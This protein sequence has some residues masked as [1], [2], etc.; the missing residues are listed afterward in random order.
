M[1]NRCV[2]IVSAKEPFVRWL[3]SLPEPDDSTVDQV[4]EET[5]A[6]LL[7]DDWDDR[8]EQELLA[9]FYDLIFEDQLAGWWTE[10]GDW[11]KRRDFTMFTRWFDVEFHS[12]VLDLV[13]A[14]L[15][16]GD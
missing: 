12:V 11:P 14:P 4:N 13:D 16:D 7:P 9:N 2:A 1:L 3:R 6:Y 15:R 8:E 10:S 5:T